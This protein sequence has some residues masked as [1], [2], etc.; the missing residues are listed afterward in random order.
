MYVWKLWEVVAAEGSPERIIVKA[1]Q[2]CISATWVKVADGMSHFR[3]VGN[4]VAPNPV[5]GRIRWTAA[6]QLRAKQRYWNCA[7]PFL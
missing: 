2:A 7:Q 4:E 3:D 1:K 5:T 6:L